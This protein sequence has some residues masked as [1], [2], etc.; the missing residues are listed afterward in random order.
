MLQPL[1][2]IYIRLMQMTVLPYLVLTLVVGLGQL[3]AAHARR[4]AV[5]GGRAAVVFWWARLAVI[6]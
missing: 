2:D 3:D 5:R 4:L 1:A 6:A